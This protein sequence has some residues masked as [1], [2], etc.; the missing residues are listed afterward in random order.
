[1]ISRTSEGQLLAASGWLRNSGL[2]Q[3]FHAFT[4][5]QRDCL[6]APGSPEAHG[7]QVSLI[8]QPEILEQ[9]FGAL[10]PNQD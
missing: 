5:G 6:H 4:I 9:E 1:M 7:M 10:F 2:K 8:R 3:N